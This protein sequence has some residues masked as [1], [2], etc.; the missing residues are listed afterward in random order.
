MKK[1][2]ILSVFSSLLMSCGLLFTT[3]NTPVNTLVLSDG[4][5]LSTDE[6]NEITPFVIH[7]TNGTSYLFFSSDRSNSYDIYY[8]II[9]P[10]GTFEK[11]KILPLSINTSDLDELFPV[12]YM[13]GNYYKIA[14][15]RISNN[16]TN[17]LCA[18]S[19]DPLFSAPTFYNKLFSGNLTGLGLARTKSGVY[20]LLT[21]SKSSTQY[22]M[23]LSSDG[24]YLVFAT[25]LLSACYSANE[26]SVPIQNGNSDLYIKA[27]K[28]GTKFQTAAELYS[29][30][31]II[32]QIIIPLVTNYTLTNTVV[33]S[34]TIPLDPYN[35]IFNDISPFVDT[36]DNFKVYFA[37]DRY[38]GDSHKG[39]YDLYRFNIYTFTNLPATKN[40]ITVDNTAPIINFGIITNG[41]TLYSGELP[42]F[43]NDNI[44]NGYFIKLYAGTNINELAEQYYDS[45]FNSW[46]LYLYMNGQYL[47]IYCYA[48]DWFGNVSATNSI[49]IYD[50]GA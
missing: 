37:S 38:D 42:I 28:A 44:C 47:T 27:V 31:T 26:F 13:E 4:T 25:N 1:F 36:K 48:E 45:F 12:V 15:L 2:F 8:S 49:Y 23:S 30:I 41:Q 6:Y 32:T 10:D 33:I 20:P 17:I 9:N 18:Y 50:Q 14:F 43:V 11:P 29:R 7:D 5:Y 40:L 21:V 46:T 19:S 35:S 34:N 22:F 16:S 39:D 3:G 24:F